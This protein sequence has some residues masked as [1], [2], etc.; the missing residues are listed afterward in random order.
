MII[1]WPVKNNQIII[2]E[3]IQFLDGIPVEIRIPDDAVK[4]S[5]PEQSENSP[6]THSSDAEQ[7]R[8]IARQQGAS[9]M[10]IHG[11]V[12][13][14]QIILYQDIQL[15]D[16]TEVEIQ[17]PDDAITQES[18]LCGIWQ[19]DRDVEEIIAEIVGSRTFGKDITL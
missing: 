5:S 13:N 1:P 2:D 6:G 3:D 15:P 16:G 19:D 4:S 9:Q 12:K 7:N 8:R 10:I 17:I 18:G 11:R 14:N